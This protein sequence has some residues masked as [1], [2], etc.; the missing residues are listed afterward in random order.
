[1]NVRRMLRSSSDVLLAA[2]AC[3]LV[4]CAASAPAARPAQSPAPPPA[5][6]SELHAVQRVHRASFEDRP[7]M[8]LADLGQ[9]WWAAFNPR[10]CAIDMVWRGDV[11]WRG[12]VYDFSQGNSQARGSVALTRMDPIA[13]MEAAVLTDEG[14][15]NR[16]TGL[17]LSDFRTAYIAFDEQRRSPVRCE[18]VEHTGGVREVLLSFESSTSHTSETE[19]MWNFKQV[20]RAVCDRAR[21]A[22]LGMASRAAT[23]PIRNLRVYG[24]RIAWR[25]AA[26]APLPAEWGGYSLASGELTLRFTV[27]GAPVELRVAA[28]ADGTGVALRW[29]GVPTTATLDGH[30]VPAQQVIAMP[31]AGSAPARAEG[32][33]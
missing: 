16:L 3:S 23:K 18:L 8:L 30:S 11:D 27:D 6:R 7:G 9:G 26:G 20:P 29:T 31:A 1:M 12:K 17:D 4:G 2:A 33:S 15:R 13:A 21:H 25:G 5:S 22:S 19:W 32:A 24:E 28:L 10:T 14:P